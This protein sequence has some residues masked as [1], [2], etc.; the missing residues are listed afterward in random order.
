MPTCLRLPHALAAAAA[1]LVAATPLRAQSADPAADAD[2]H[3]A[4]QAFS[5]AYGLAQAWPRMAPKIARDSLPRLRE[6]ALDD[7]AAD[8]LLDADA[9]RRAAARLE[10]LLPAAR[11]DLEAALRTLDADE[12]AA[13]TA[14]EVYAKLF[15]T[16]EIK[17][18]TAFFGSPTGRKLNAEAPAVLAEARLPGAKDTMTRHFSEDERREIAAFWSSSVGMKM[19]RTADTVR[20]Q[21]HEH[22]MVRSDAAVR[23]LAR[24]LADTAEAEPAE[25]GPTR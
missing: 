2:R 13:F 15:E 24:R 9:R 3:A 7:I 12:L 1:L 14:Y 10:S 17:A 23:D 18:L 16:E 20:D 4:L 19:A 22:F 5:Q 6:R 11:G 8:P 21:V 25:A